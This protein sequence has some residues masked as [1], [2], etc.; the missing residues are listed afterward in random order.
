MCWNSAM[1]SFRRIHIGRFPVAFDVDCMQ[2]RYSPCSWLDALLIACLVSIMFSRTVA[3]VGVRRRFVS[4][5]K[6]KGVGNN[7]LQRLL[8]VNVT[9]GSSKQTVRYSTNE[10]ASDS[11]RAT[12]S[13][14]EKK[15]FHRLPTTVRPYHYDISL[16]PNL[17]TFTFDGT[18]TV[19]IDVSSTAQSTTRVTFILPALSVVNH[20]TNHSTRRNCR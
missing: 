15:P 2:S 17:S 3:R 12:M 10:V 5:Q 6:G 8:L 1:F 7:S 4:Q 13:S 14:N 19:H 20:S 18:E 11:S 16:T 9:V